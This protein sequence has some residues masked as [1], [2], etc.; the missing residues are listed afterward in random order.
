MIDRK[1]TPTL[2]LLSFKEVSSWSQ[3]F[4]HAFP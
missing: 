3:G 2:R 4:F 1:I